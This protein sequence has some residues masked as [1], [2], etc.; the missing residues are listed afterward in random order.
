MILSIINIRKVPREMLKTSS[1]ALGFQQP[2][3]DLANVNPWVSPSVFNTPL[4]TLT[5]IPS[6]PSHSQFIKFKENKM[7]CEKYK[8]DTY[9]FQTTKVRLN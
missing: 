7:I 1:F 5:F 2:L 4:G 9:E 3:R 6:A 8:P